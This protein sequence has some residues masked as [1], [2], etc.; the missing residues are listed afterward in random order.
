MEAAR[1][2]VRGEEL[3]IAYRG[4]LGLAE[5]VELQ[6]ELTGLAEACL[7]WAWHF[8]GKPKWAWIGLGKLGGEALSLGSDLD[9]LIVGEGEEAA[10]KAIRFLTEDL[11]TG[12]LFKV[13][14]RL[15]PYAE[16][17]LVVPAK[18]YAEYYN[19]EAQAWEVQA[20]SRARNVGGAKELGKA[21]WPAVEKAWS[22]T[23]QEK[24]FFGEVKAM[25]ERIAVERVKSGEEERAYKT[26]RGG[27][28]D[29]EFAAQAWQMREG[30]VEARTG[31]VLE[32]MAGK[33][34]KEAKVLREGLAFWSAAEWWL[35]LD[36]GRG[37]SLLPKSGADL[38]WLSQRCG[39]GTGAEFMKEAEKMRLRVR[40][41]YESV[42]G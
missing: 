29:V 21:F 27:L 30:M 28:I 17:A 2:Y 38:D 31:K 23:G 16:G 3:R 6:A 18:R 14:F 1:L 37:G 19:K 40:A 15:R 4:L 39:A 33:F 22:K 9:L 8:A 25:R 13:D 7:G 20:L 10:Q 12:T 36:E 32:A 34:P 24:K 41:A 35:R 11:S 26:G 42:L 5:V